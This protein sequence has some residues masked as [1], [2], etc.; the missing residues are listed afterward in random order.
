[1]KLTRVNSSLNKK[2]INLLAA[3]LFL[4]QP[5]DQNFEKRTHMAQVP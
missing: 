4:G 1:M 5:K 3:E 2:T